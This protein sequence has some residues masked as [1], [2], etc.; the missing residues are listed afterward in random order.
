LQQ[1]GIADY[2]SRLEAESGGL[3]LGVDTL[4]LPDVAHALMLDVRWQSVANSMHS[5]LS[6]TFSRPVADDAG[7]AGG[8][9]HPGSYQG[10]YGMHV[11]GNL[12]R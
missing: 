4:A 11:L 10:D 9:I 1:Y 8:T 2:V 7:R 6:A 5:W 12:V 3:L